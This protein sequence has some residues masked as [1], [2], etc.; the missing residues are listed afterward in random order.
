MHVPPAQRPDVEGSVAARAA[1][2]STVHARAVR[3]RR[4]G[5]VAFI[6]LLALVVLGA[7]WW[8]LPLESPLPVAR[9]LAT[10]GR[11]RASPLAPLVALACFVVGGVL[12]FPVN[13]LTAATI[14]V[15]GAVAGA[16]W[17]LLGAVL[18]AI[19]VHEIGR[20]L[21]ATLVARLAGAR[22]ERLR[23][24][25]VGHGL[26][27]IAVVRIVP[28]APYSVIS[29]VAGVARIRRFDYIAGTA[30]GMLP[31]IVLYAV[32]IDRARATLLDPHPLAWLGLLGALV[33]IAAA[34]VGLRHWRRREA[35]D[36]AA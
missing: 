36:P 33:L 17:A 6:L 14:I 25:V 29:L 34:A 13:V 12:V 18:S 27:A 30:L 2:A 3:R 8:W 28:L 35:G 24:R 10:A 20:R 16:A 4:R 26:L 9:W 19:V 21:P 11:W 5:L 7:A 31:G 32:F 15:F 1:A 22:G 23:A